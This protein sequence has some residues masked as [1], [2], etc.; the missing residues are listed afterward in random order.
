M[1]MKCDREFVLFSTQLQIVL[2]RL[3]PEAQDLTDSSENI[4]PKLEGRAVTLASLD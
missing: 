3:V 2:R 4:R 1:G